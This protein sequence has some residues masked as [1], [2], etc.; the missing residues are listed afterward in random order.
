MTSITTIAQ[1]AALIG[2]PA[3][4]TML[5]T[6]MDGRAFTASELA[7]QAG[8]TKQTAS[9]H[10]A[11]LRQGG[12]LSREIQGRHHYFK[13][14]DEEAAHL[15]ETLMNFTERQSG[16]PI[17]I[18]PK[19]PALRK[20]RICYDHLA[21][22]MG[23]YVYEQMLSKDWLYV[24]YGEPNLTELGEEKLSAF[25]VDIEAFNKSRRPV[26]RTCLDWSMRRHHLAGQLG[27]ALLACF[28]EKK[29]LYRDE[30]SRALHFYPQTEQA[31]LIWLR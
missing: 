6:L 11:K 16:S 13:L 12:L 26:C 8:V 25:G 15:L 18:G 14:K 17:R 20:A 10:L 30:K 22:E 24:K 9:S 21:G 7:T 1:I 3:R 23:V 29:W 5:M 19:D 27:A 28:L 2:D 4:A 31:L